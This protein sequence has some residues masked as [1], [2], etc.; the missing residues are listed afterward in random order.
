[1]V[2]SGIAQQNGFLLASQQGLGNGPCSV[3]HFCGHGGLNTS[4]LRHGDGHAGQSRHPRRAVHQHLVA[5]RHR[6]VLGLGMKSADL[7]PFAGRLADALREQGMVL[8]QIGAHHQD[9]LKGRQGCDGH[10]QPAGGPGSGGVGEVGMAQTGVDVLAAQTAHQG[11]S[12]G[13]LFECAVRTGQHTDRVR[14]MVSLDL[15][16]AIGHVFQSG[17]PVHGRP[18]AALFEHGRGQAVFAVDGFVRETV[19]VGDPAFVHRVIFEWHHA[20]DLVVFHL[21]DQVGTGGVVRAHRLA[22]RQLPGTGAVTEGLAGQRTHGANVDHVARQLGVHRLADKGFDLGVFAPMRHAQLHHAANF[23]TKAHAAGAVDATAHLFHGNER[24]HVLVEHHAFFFFVARRASAVA[25]GQILQL[26]FP[27][28]VTDR[29]I[30]RVV[31][32][33]ELHHRLL[34]LD[35]LLTLGAHNHA[36]GHGRGT[37]GHGLGRLFHFHQAHATAGRDG[38]LLV[39]AEMRDVGARLFGRMH[40]HAA[41]WHFDLLAVEFDFNHGFSSRFRRWRRP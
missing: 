22:A 2:S 4:L 29:A 40:D 39:V 20:H 10:A 3:R 5:H 1:M 25:H 37:G 16:Q 15:L 13:Q 35:G 32:E 28:L 41:R 38:Q 36:H 31:D 12:Q 17:L 21:N 11:T 8:A 26:A 14:A 27:T 33:Q 34:G 24:P 6:P 19:T 7:A 23:L 30:Q 9:A 18:L